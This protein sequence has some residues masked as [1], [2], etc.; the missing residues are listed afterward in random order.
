M[1]DDEDTQGD[2]DTG[3]LAGEPDLSRLKLVPSCDGE[4]GLKVE[5]IPEGAAQVEQPAHGLT[6]VSYPKGNEIP[7][8]ATTGDRVLLKVRERRQR[9][10]EREGYFRDYKDGTGRPGDAEAVL[11]A[12]SQHD[13][14]VRQ[15]RITWRH[16]LLVA[17]SNALVETNEKQ[18][19]DKL[20]EVAAIVVAWQEAIEMRGQKARILAE[21]GA[22]KWERGSDGSYK[23]RHLMPWWK[24]FLKALRLLK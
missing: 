21:Q 18:L 22:V 6:L 17:I 2:G 13:E 24:R 9:H 15:V 16:K 12:V 23:K 7:R 4:T 8:E 10:D 1:I 5:S 11:V 20:T 19:A 3:D 14:A